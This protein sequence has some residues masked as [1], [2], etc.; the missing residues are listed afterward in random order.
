MK[1]DK[2]KDLMLRSLTFFMPNTPLPAGTGYK[3]NGK[4]DIRSR[5]VRNFGG[6]H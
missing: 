1:Y 5:D 6:I 2:K 3:K 4:H